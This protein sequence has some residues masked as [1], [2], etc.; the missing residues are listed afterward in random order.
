M[1]PFDA[2]V[3]D[4]GYAIGTSSADRAKTVERAAEGARGGSNG[5]L[6]ANCPF[7]PDRVGKVDTKYCLSIREDSGVYR[8]W[9]CGVKGRVAELATRLSGDGAETWPER[10][11]RGGDVFLWLGPPEG[12]CSLG[13]ESSDDPLV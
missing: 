5:W 1:S 13:R 4:Y 12:F 6:R 2:G 7:C 3:G 9:R 11:R 8:C 10:V